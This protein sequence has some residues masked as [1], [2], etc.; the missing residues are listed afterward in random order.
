MA[1]NTDK[2]IVPDGAPGATQPMKSVTFGEALTL[3]GN[4]V[5]TWPKIGGNAGDVMTDDGAGNLSLQPKTATNKTNISSNTTLTDDGFEINVF[6]IDATS[7]P[8]TITLPLLSTVPNQ[9]YLFIKVDSSDNKV[10]VD[11]DGS[12]TINGALTQRFVSEF[13]S[14]TL[15]PNATEWFILNEHPNPKT[16]FVDRNGSGVQSIA[17]GSPVVVQL[18]NVIVDSGS[19]YDGVTNFDYTPGNAIFQMVVS[20]ELLQLDTNDFVEICLRKNGTNIIC[21][22]TFATQNNQNLTVTINDINTNTD[23]SPGVYDLTIEHNQ[24]GNLDL[25]ADPVTTFWKIIRVS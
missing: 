4:G 5:L 21:S 14:M 16:L 8:I 11:G 22:R 24:G 7:G 12:E 17:S 6:E 10:T 18:D 9:R 13:D 19:F 2:F 15:I 3:M 20:V 23:P 25:S 1:L